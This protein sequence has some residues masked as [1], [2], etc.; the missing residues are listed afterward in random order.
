[1]PGLNATIGANSSQYDKALDAAAARAL[2]TGRL[3]QIAMTGEAPNATA[4]R[5]QQIRHQQ[6]VME[7]QERLE[8]KAA[9]FG[10]YR[11][12]LAMQEAAAT[13]ESAKNVEQM[14][15]AR[16][17][18][19]ASAA[20][21]VSVGRDTAA[22][23]A[24]GA[25][26]ITVFM[27]QFPQVMQAFVMMGKEGFNA[28]KESVSSGLSKLVGN[29]GGG[30]GVAAAGVGSVALY[31][32][33]SEE[34]KMFSALSESHENATK[35]ADMLRNAVAK[36]VV[37]FEK[38]ADRGEGSAKRA[39]DMRAAI[40]GVD[41]GD[42]AQAFRAFKTVMGLAGRRAPNAAD[43]TSATDLLRQMNAESQEDPAERFRLQAEFRR[44]KAIREGEAVAKKAD[45][46][47][48]IFRDYANAV[49]EREMADYQSSKNKGGGKSLSM[50][51]DWERA[52]G[53]LGGQN[54]MLDV[55]KAQLT[56]LRE[57][58]NYVRQGRGV[59]F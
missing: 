35:T 31:E 53:S 30:V 58:K 56:E 59:T 33:L 28:L 25:N 21:F 55:S 41:L 57:I 7:Y 40:T 15:R 29:M 9:G 5:A 44:D 42:P 2:K 20:M 39:R 54:L 3:I 10:A 16:A 49:F 4:I 46:N 45:L 38:L 36:M 8:R 6:A 27:Q 24:S 12:S 51:T 34:Y 50:L 17:W 32:T 1:M 23:L 37:E 13:A 26:P 11:A 47:P 22:S 48:Q 14:T 43:V 52:G 18:G 19:G